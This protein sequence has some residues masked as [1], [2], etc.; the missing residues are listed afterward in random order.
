V[1]S[2]QVRLEG[3]AIH[4]AAHAVV[5]LELQIPVVE[6][7]VEDADNGLCQVL[8]PSD[9]TI[10]EW[11]KQL[12]AVAAGQCAQWEN[13]RVTCKTKSNQLDNELIANYVQKLFHFNGAQIRKI[14]IPHLQG[15]ELEKASDTTVD[16]VEQ[17][18]RGWRRSC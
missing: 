14:S 11:R 10:A 5:A 2:S 1:I 7:V 13:R 4:E 16:L 8:L 6:V 15:K 12:I 3:T 17:N 18:E 9:D